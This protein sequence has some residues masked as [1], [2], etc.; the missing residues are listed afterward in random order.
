MKEEKT[1]SQDQRLAVRLQRDFRAPAAKVFGAWA[2]PAFITKWWKNLTVAKIDFRTGGD[3][4][5]RWESWEGAVTGTYREIVP[6]ERIVFTWSPTPQSEGCAESVVT[7]ELEERGDITRLTLTH[8][9]NSTKAEADSHRDGWT[10][11]LADL[12]AG[13]P[14]VPSPVAVARNIKAPAAKIYA[15]LTQS[16]ELDRW[17]FP[18]CT[19]DP[20]E[21]G[22]YEIQW[23][24]KED[25]ERNHRRFGRFLELVENER[26]RFEWRGLSLDNGKAPTEVTIELTQRDDGST[27]LLLTHDGWGTSPPWFDS[28]DQHESGWNFYVGNL[29]G[30]L[31]ATG[32]LRES[33]FGQH[34]TSSSVANA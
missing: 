31:H 9:L 11:A 10:T 19:T 15:A 8:D 3:F 13:Y 17:F 23:E 16:E 18:R 24:S 34:V 22:E 4:E 7:L 2:D 26:L 29:A 14:R 21:G 27:D 25:P 1:M 30:Y 32:D 12:A 6:N 33:F 5:F 28:R 20:R